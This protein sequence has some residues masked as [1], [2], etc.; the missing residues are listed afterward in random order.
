M[1]QQRL[2]RDWQI[3]DNFIKKS[4]VSELRVLR[5]LRVSYVSGTS[6]ISAGGGSYSS[7]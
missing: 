3:T 2:L 7:R 6:R 5:V 4:H 1:A